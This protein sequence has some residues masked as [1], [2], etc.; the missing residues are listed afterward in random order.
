MNAENAVRP[1]NLG[2]GPTVTKSNLSGS[3]ASSL[4]TLKNRDSD[5][6][7]RS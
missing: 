4:K 1:G 6:S 7:Y 5:R 2:D 3:F